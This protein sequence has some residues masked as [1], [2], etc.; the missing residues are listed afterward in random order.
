MGLPSTRTMPSSG[1]SSPLTSCRRVDFPLPLSPTMAVTLPLVNA[2]LSRS[3]L[4][5]ELYRKTTSSK[6]IG[7]LIVSMRESSKFLRQSYYV[8]KLHHDSEK[9]SRPDFRA[10]FNLH[11][12]GYSSSGRCFHEVILNY[13][14]SQNTRFVTSSPPMAAAAAV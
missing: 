2:T 11:L 6:E 12:V 5:S 1:R 8:R 9:R 14:I 4:D 7:G 3:G 13:L 10:A